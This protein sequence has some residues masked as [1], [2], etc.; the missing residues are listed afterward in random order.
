MRKFVMLSVILCCLLVACGNPGSAATDTLPIIAQTQPLQTEAPAVDSFRTI[1]PLPATADTDNC[2][3]AV[4]LEKAGIGSNA[5]TVTV[6]D[7][8]LYDMVDIATLKG[9][10]T[11]VIRGEEVVIEALE[12]DS[13]GGVLINGGP[14]M[15]GYLLRTDENTVYYEIGFNDAKSWQPVKELTATVSEDFTFTDASDPDKGTVTYSFADMAA[16][17]SQ[18]YFPL[19]PANTTAIIENS[20]IMAMER[21]YTP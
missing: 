20:V 10:D 19:Q 1:L 9:G 18:I 5:L 4:S 2:T 3:V 16:A 21:F 6:Y 12:Q 14:D 8:D 13:F 11:I 7:Y 15:D 17:D